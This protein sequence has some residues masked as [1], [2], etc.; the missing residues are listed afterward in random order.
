MC[1]LH[2]HKI[3]NNQRIVRMLSNSFCHAEFSSASMLV[4]SKQILKQVQD[5]ILRC[6]LT[7]IDNNGGCVELLV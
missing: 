6:H 7:A 2:K 1:L 3:K 5:D 4:G